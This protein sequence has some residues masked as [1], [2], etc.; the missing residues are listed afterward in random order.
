MLLNDLLKNVEI[1]IALPTIEECM[2]IPAPEDCTITIPST[3][4]CIVIPL[5]ARSSLLI[6][7]PYDLYLKVFFKQNT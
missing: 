4:N 2:L 7:L 3:H 1:Y 6:C 5:F